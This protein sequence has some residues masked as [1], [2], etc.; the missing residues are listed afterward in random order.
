MSAPAK[1][2]VQIGSRR[3]SVSVEDEF[4]AGLR[5]MARH[6]GMTIQEM[7]NEIAGQQDLKNLSAAIRLAVLRHF[8]AL[9]SAK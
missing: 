5:E 1:R 2:G 9:A 4:W 8:Q 6:R 7:T 3:T